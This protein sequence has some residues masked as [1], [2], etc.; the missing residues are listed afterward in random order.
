MKEITS[1]TEMT[2]NPEDKSLKD[3]IDFLLP[4]KNDILNYFKKYN[5][6]KSI[7]TFTATD[8]ITGE[9]SDELIKCFDDGVYSWTNEEIYHFEKYN[10]KLNDDFVNHALSQAND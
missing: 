3:F 1:Y 9:K 6:I 5:D 7:I 8:Y 2:E 4:N 10:L